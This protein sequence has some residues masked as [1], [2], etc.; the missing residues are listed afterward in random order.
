MCENLSPSVTR[1]AMTSL[2][3][4]QWGGGARSAHSWIRHCGQRDKPLIVGLATH[5]FSI[6]V[7]SHAVS[8]SHCIYIMLFIAHSA[9]AC[10]YHSH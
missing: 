8:V 10:D 5:G 9:Q 3:F 2:N 7:K 4:G 6:I 1:A